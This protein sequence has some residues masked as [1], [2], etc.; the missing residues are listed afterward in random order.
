MTVAKCRS[1]S[2][3]KGGV[4]MMRTFQFPLPYDWHYKY[5]HAVDNH[6]NLRHSL[7]S[8]E[9]TI[10]TTCW[11]MCVFSF[12]LAV[13]EVNAFLAYRFLVKPNTVLSL[14]QF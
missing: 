7:P 10:K 6:N 14:Q 5:C 11:E 4:K 3:P 12:V 1:R 13:S 2:G 9:H 8:I